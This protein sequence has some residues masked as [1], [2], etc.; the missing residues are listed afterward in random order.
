MFKYVD[1]EI[2]ETT[3]NEVT[4][5]IDSHQGINVSNTTCTENGFQS[6]NILHL[7]SEKILKKIVFINNLH[8]LIF[9]IHYIKYNEGGYQKEHIH[10]ND[11]YSF[12]LYLNDSD[13]NTVLGN[14]VNKKFSPKKGK[15]IIFSGKTVHYCEPSFKRK[16]VLVGAI[17]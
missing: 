5:I 11:E 12:I 8:K 9:H 17:K 16:T 6:D 7:F 13:G 15:I 3:L 1:Y 14:P 2:D 4:K 10:E